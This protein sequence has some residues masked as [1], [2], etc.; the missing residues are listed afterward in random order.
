MTELRALRMAVGLTTY[1]MAELLDCCQ[2][3]ISMAERNVG[4]GPIA[5]R[6]EE[7]LYSCVNVLSNNEKNE[8]I[9]IVAC[10][11]RW[12]ANKAETRAHIMN[13]EV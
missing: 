4:C 7:F 6:E 13:M 10:L 11:M 2:A 1:E 3:S 12:D 9:G 5:K 8:I